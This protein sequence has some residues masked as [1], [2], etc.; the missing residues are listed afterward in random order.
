MSDELKGGKNYQVFFMSF[1]GWPSGIDGDSGRGEGVWERS[2]LGWRSDILQKIWVL[3]VMSLSNTQARKMLMVKA[4]ELLAGR[5]LGVGGIRRNSASVESARPDSSRLQVSIGWVTPLSR[6]QGYEELFLFSHPSPL[7]LGLEVPHQKS[8][9]C[10]RNDEEHC[11]IEQDCPG[12]GTHRPWL[13]PES[14]LSR[15]SLLIITASLSYN[16]RYCL[17]VAAGGRRSGEAERS[18]ASGSARL[19]SVLSSEF[20]AVISCR[21]TSRFSAKVE[22]SAVISCRATSRFSAKLEFSAVI[23]CRATSRFSAKVEFS[24]VISCR[25]TSRFSAK[26]E[27]SAVISCRAKSRFSAKVEFSAVISCRATSRFSAKLEFSAVISCRATSRFSA[28]VEFSAVISCRA[29]S[30]FSVKVEFSAVI[31]CRATSRFSAKFRVFCCPRLW[32]NKSV[33]CKIPCFLLSSA[34]GQQFGSVQNSVFSAC[35]PGLWGNKSM[36]KLSQVDPSATSLARLKWPRVKSL[37][38]I[39]RGYSVYTVHE[40]RV[41]HAMP[42]RHSR[43]NLKQTHARGTDHSNNGGGGLHWSALPCPV[44]AKTSRL[45]RRLNH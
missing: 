1:H 3:F 39:K 25:A 2:W 24:A 33:Q 27:F 45:Q 44:H 35:C 14:F 36:G 37:A 11:E 19:G 43:T 31:S 38:M 13:S 9:Y 17:G 26:L 18:K 40:E 5:D 7:E 29:T 16:A 20:S 23:S 28:K 15:G 34:V 22:F 6:C 21:A 42:A 8:R 10:T 41:P 12:H 32:G 4:V 30:R